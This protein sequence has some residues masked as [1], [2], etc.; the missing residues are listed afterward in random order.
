MF[1]NCIEYKVSVL[2]DFLCFVKMFHNIFCKWTLAY[3]CVITLCLILH[4]HNL[5]EKR[6]LA[7]IQ[8]YT[9]LIFFH[10]NVEFS[11][12]NFLSPKCRVWFFMYSNWCRKWRNSRFFCDCMTKFFINFYNCLTFIFFC[13][14][15]TKF[16]IFSTTD[17]RNS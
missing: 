7:H 8:F 2:I 11:S 9:T 14:R 10:P 5:F 4:F 3:N 6:L 12:I 13:K 17:W 1:I 16:A 15:L